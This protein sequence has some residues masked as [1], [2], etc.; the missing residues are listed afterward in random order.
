MAKTAIVTGGARGLGEGMALKLAEMGYH[1]VINYVSDHS[2]E[3]SEK[4]V[5]KI[6]EEYSVDAMAIQADVSDYAECKKLYDATAEKF[7]PK[8]DVLVNNAGI[9]N[10]LSFL[11]ITPE[12][13]KRVIDVNLMSYMHMC[14]LVLPAMAEAKD[15]CIINLSSI[16]GLMG[17][18][19]QGDYCASKSGVIGLTRALAIEFG[20]IGLR[21]NA[22]APGMIWTDMLRSVDQVAVEYLK[23]TIPMG[24]I[25]EVADISEAME[26]LVNAKYM[27]GQVISPNGGI[28]MP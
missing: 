19:E 14:H 7:G 9:T 1:V 22:I 28:I 21:V 12:Q 6:K 13:Y 3:L 2:R 24:E 26:Y 16:G 11:K 25:G 8:V 27:T 15:G 10:N 18:S 20:K 23:T 17:V 5:S 4:L